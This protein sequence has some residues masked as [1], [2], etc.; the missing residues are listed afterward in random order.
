MSCL[1]VSY[2]DSRQTPAGFTLSDLLT[3]IIPGAVLTVT[4][5][6][7]LYGN[8]V[9]LYLLGER[10]LQLPT[11]TSLTLSLVLFAL[12]SFVIGEIV[13]LLRGNLIPVPYLFRRMVFDVTGNREA[14][15][16]YQRFL[17]YIFEHNSKFKLLQ[18]LLSF[19]KR[20]FWDLNRAWFNW[21]T[22]TDGKIQ[23]SDGEADAGFLEYY[24]KEMD[25]SSTFYNSRILYMSLYTFLEGQMSSMTQQHQT[26]YNAAVNFRVAS[27]ASILIIF[28]H[29][30]Q[31]R[32]AGDTERQ[33]IALILLSIISL[34]YIFLRMLTNK[35]KIIEKSYIES[36][37]IN[38]LI[39]KRS[40]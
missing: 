27:I 9:S 13:D 39:I 10:S 23:E 3:R 2:V 18:K 12:L 11:G 32:I 4:F 26:A 31:G 38:Y 8:R 25:I 6:L 21:S 40:D 24:R 37:M 5:V 33:V 28:V 20:K 22:T 17:L 29:F 34:T 7:P 14:L 36:L 16:M 19:L 30:V 35:F 1:F 15:S